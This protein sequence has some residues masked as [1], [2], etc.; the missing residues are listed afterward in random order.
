MIKKQAYISCLL[1]TL[2]VWGNVVVA[3]TNK[4]LEFNVVKPSVGVSLVPSY[5]YLI[6]E[7]PHKISVVSKDN[8]AVLKLKLAGGSVL[9]RDN[10]TVLIAENLNGNG[11]MLKVY[12][13]SDGEE[14]L[15]TTKSYDVIDRPELYIDNQKVGFK[16]AGV[17]DTNLFS[18]TLELKAAYKNTLITFKLESFNFSMLSQGT[19]Y[20]WSIKGNRLHKKAL[21]KLH[22]GYYPN[23]KAYFEKMAFEFT[24]GEKQ[25]ANVSVVK[26]K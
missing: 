19:L 1:L 4:Q 2:L 16:L 20:M 24:P 26:F 14:K 25:M 17:L 9:I 15:L 12:D 10:D 22:D 18:K 7:T 11:V 6:H 8:N 5:E 13:I 21:K 23:M 3:Q